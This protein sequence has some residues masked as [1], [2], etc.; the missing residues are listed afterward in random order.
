MADLVRRVAVQPSAKVVKV[1]VDGVVYLLT[2]RTPYVVSFRRDIHA[3]K[4][5]S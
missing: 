3:K 2:G 5:K 4:R 1:L